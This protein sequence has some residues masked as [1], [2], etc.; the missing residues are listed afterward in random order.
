MIDATLRRVLEEEA[1]AISAT[2]KRLDQAFVAAV[3][4]FVAAKGRVITCGL[5]KSG[6]VARK[7]AATL[8]STGTPSFF[9]HAAEAVHGDLG[10]VTG[11]DVVL[12]YSYSGETEVVQLV[13]SFNRAGAKTIAITGRVGSTLAR[14]ADVVL[15]VSVPKEAD[16]HN[17]APTTSTTLMLAVSDAL[18]VAT[19]ESRGFGKDDFARFHPAGALGR[20]LTLTVR[21]VMRKGPDLPL[22]RPESLLADCLATVGEKGAGGAVVVDDLQGLKGYFTDG[23]LRR[24][25]MKG[26]SLSVSAGEVATSNPRT[27]EPGML[28]FEALEFFENLIAKIG[29]IPVVEDGKVVGLLVLKDLVRAGLI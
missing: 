15:D 13:P 27:L 4:L 16:L 5:G 7:T 6:H 23:D 3:E 19:M 8:A 12:V 18:A 28:A 9:L 2:A 22:V 14:L 11:D 21:D 24:W 25:I 26:G 17:L 10:M 29:E 1:A 20:R